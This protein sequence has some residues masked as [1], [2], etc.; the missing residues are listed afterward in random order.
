MISTPEQDN[1]KYQ[2]F[3]RGSLD[4]NMDSLEN[5]AKTYNTTLVTGQ[6]FTIACDGVSPSVCLGIYENGNVYV[7]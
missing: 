4:Q 1:K 7:I 2:I 3:I 6:T 5:I